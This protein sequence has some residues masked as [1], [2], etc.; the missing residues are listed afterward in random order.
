[1]PL[2][3]LRDPLV[4]IPTGSGVPFVHQELPYDECTFEDDAEE[5]EDDEE[6]EDNGDKDNEE[7][8]EDEDDGGGVKKR[9]K[10]AQATSTQAKKHA[11]ATPLDKAYAN[12]L[13]HLTDM[14]ACFD[15]FVC[16]RRIKAECAERAVR[17]AEEHLRVCT[18]FA[19][20]GGRGGY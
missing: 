7:E 16:D 14:R 1:M 3:A 11:A 18:G 10:R 4:S 2:H 15:S 13:A 6:E 20:G 12:F 8:D 17:D 9:P 5:D 19:E